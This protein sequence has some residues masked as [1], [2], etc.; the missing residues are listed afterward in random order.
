MAPELLKIV[1]PRFE[2]FQDF[3]GAEPMVEMRQPVPIARH[4]RKFLFGKTPRQDLLL[5][6]KK[7]NI[8]VRFGGHAGLSGE[9][10]GA[11]IQTGLQG[12]V[13][14]VVSDTEK[15]RIGAEFVERKV[16][17]TA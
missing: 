14:I 6:H 16:P 5:G 4:G 17:E 11:D 9:D 3:G 8:S 12:G 15:I 1:Q 10:M 7:G 13:K 2:D